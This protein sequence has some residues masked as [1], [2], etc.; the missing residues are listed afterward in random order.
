M[1]FVKASLVA[2]FKTEIPILL[3]AGSVLREIFLSHHIQ[4]SGC[5]Q[6]PV[7]RRLLTCSLADRISLPFFRS[8]AVSGAVRIEGRDAANDKRRHCHHHKKSHWLEF[9]GHDS[10]RES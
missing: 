1:R 8:S 3:I 6:F 10:A 2:V 5:W 4:L 9:F 7:A